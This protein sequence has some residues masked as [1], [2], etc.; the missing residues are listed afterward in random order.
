MNTV[1]EGS[2]ISPQI[3]LGRPRALIPLSLIY[4][5]ADFLPPGNG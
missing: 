3:I 4:P 2:F 5:A 1:R